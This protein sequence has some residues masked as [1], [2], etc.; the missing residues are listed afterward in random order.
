M[1]VINE[2]MN[3]SNE[4]IKSFFDKYSNPIDILSNIDNEILRIGKDLDSNEYNLLKEN[5]WVHKTCKISNSV[6]IIGPAIIMENA[7]LKH[8]A[9]I[10][11]NVIIGKNVT[12][13]NS[14][15]IKNSIIMDNS[16]IPHFN[17]VGDSIL[18]NHVHFGAGVIT[19]N[20]R[21]DKKNIKINH[22]DTKLRKVG[23]FIGDNVEIGVNSV[24][25][26][27]TIIY[28]NVKIYP[29]ERVKGIINE[30]EILNTY[31]EIKRI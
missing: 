8:N 27:G 4:L 29:L 3:V 24:I 30:S 2:L 6:E 1:V 25:Y 9:Y 11:E 22:E 19:A 7:C 21:L 23:A 10:R 18:G 15:E 16:E 26:P 31:N 5:V 12:I 28:P 13:G 20:L 17:Y 14:S